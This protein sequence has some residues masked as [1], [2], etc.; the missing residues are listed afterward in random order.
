MSKC[1]LN[2]KEND[3]LQILEKVK[4]NYYS[5]GGPDKY[6]KVNIIHRNN[7]SSYFVFPGF[8]FYAI[9]GS[10]DFREVEENAFSKIR[11]LIKINSI[12]CRSI[13]NFPPPPYYWAYFNGIEIT[14]A[15]DYISI[16]E[17]SVPN[18]KPL[19]SRELF[20]RVYA[21]CNDTL[22]LITEIWDNL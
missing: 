12:V 22:R 11:K 13:L 14:F 18:W 19:N 2:L 6:Y 4:D 8:N 5:L 9:K 20:D 10:E 7:N 21:T 3:L 1:V 17:R 16:E 15:E